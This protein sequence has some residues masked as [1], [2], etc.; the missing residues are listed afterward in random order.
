VIVVFQGSGTVAPNQAELVR[1]DLIRLGFEPRNI[2]IRSWSGSAPYQSWAVG[3]WDIFVPTGWCAE[4]PDP[5]DFLQLLLWPA[6]V[7][8]LHFGSPKYRTKI[9]VANRLNGNA[10][11]RAF[12]NLDLEMMRDAAPVAP[13][14]TCN[15]RYL[16]SDR[17]DPRSLV[18]QGV[19]GDWSIPALK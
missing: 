18:C 15:S 3:D 6:E 11:L 5:Y 17:V 9:A 13:M 7:S 8:P 2:V 16:F 4:A 1:R 14:R 10:R 12:G 19:H